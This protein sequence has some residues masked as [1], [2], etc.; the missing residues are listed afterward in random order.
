MD[1]Y[2]DKLILFGGCGPYMESVRIRI[3]Y[4]DLHTFDTKTNKWKK[5]IDAGVLP[6]KR[7]GH[8][9][10]IMGGIYL[11]HGGTH[12]EGRTMLDDFNLYDLELEEWIPVITSMNGNVFESQSEITSDSGMMSKRESKKLIGPRH[13]HC[14]VAAYERTYY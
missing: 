7:F 11:I 2:G 8:V 1:V 12:S 4:N 3:S 10:G 6:K 14:M 9:S 5:L 13:L